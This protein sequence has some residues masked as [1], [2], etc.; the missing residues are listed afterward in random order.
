MKAYG[1]AMLVLAAASG[2]R[3][4][5]PLIP[6]PQEITPGRGGFSIT[7]SAVIYV[8]RPG[9]PEDRLAAFSLRDE[10][11]LRTG[12]RLGVRQ[13]IPREAAGI[14]LGV[15]G[16][17]EEIREQVARPVTREQGYALEVTPGSIAICG[18][19]SAGLFYGMQTLLQLLPERGSAGL[20][21]S[22]RAIPAL[23]IR[24]WPALRYRMVQYDIARGQ[25]VNVAF[26][27][28]VIRTLAHYKINQ[29]MFY[30]EDDFK[31]RAYPFLGREGT[32]THENASELSRFARDYHVELVPEIES[33]GHAGALLS[34]PELADLRDA[35]N[36]WNFCPC[37]PGTLPF[38]GNVYTEL[39]D[40]FG[41]GF[42]HVGG[43]EFEGGF[44]KD[45]RCKG[46]LAEWGFEG[47]YARYMTQLDEAVKARGRRMMIWAAH[48]N[49]LTL[50][51]GD[52]LSKNMII[53]EWIYHGP[54]EYP[55]IERYQ[56]AGFEVYVVPSVV[57]Y[58]RIYPDYETTFRAV[59]G[60]IG[61]GAARGVMGECTTTWE[62]MQGA[63]FENSWYGL[64]YSADCGWAPQQA[65]KASFDERFAALWFG[66]P[67]AGREM[68]AL[69]TDLVGGDGFWRD[70]LLVTQIF[71]ASPERVRREF[72]GPATAVG[73]D[74]RPPLPEQA[75]RLVAAADA[76]V[77]RIEALR[78]RVRR[79]HL[80]LDTVE[81]AARMYG[82][83]G[84]KM[85]LLERAA[86]AY[87][88]AAAAA[89][90][91]EMAR[92]LAEA[93]AALR[94]LLG[95]YGYFEEM[96]RD[97]ADHRGHY[98]GDVDRVA[99]QRQ[100]LQALIARLDDLR[101]AAAAGQKPALPPASE[102]ALEVAH[103]VKAAAWS[104][105]Q[106]SPEWTTVRYDIT[107]LVRAAGEYLVTW[108]Y[109][110]GALGLAIQ[111]TAIESDGKRVAED[112]HEGW[113]GAAMSNNTYRLR[114]ESVAP[115]ARYELV[116][117]VRSPTGTDSS[118]E[119]WINAPG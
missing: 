50:R 49:D 14:A 72:V 36:P 39:A 116:G 96:L 91:A 24:D 90:P 88:A 64:I 106:M 13:G 43:D 65:E 109:T 115:G 78:P 93:T 80:T 114:I 110:S 21:T 12:L 95:P 25:T 74:G 46:P 99:Q 59:R 29:L 52:R 9:S 108:R 69:L 22:G 62:L 119:I 47:L 60:F 40:A 23:T 19:D 71:W 38:L 83:A 66:A 85:V 7:P 104:P 28:H 76:A 103:W 87:R 89:E 53:F 81:L 73:A 5:P 63:L 33:L 55:T 18:A 117:R 51:A 94:E 1:W 97:A 37:A 17:D 77:A 35:G 118:G 26:C 68:G 107:P 58:S 4:A 6:Q 27:K 42:L 54:A 8:C 11:R 45:E 111:N 101:E 61:A 100:E 34:H 41:G 30:L 105:A 32:F 75:V 20:T 48:E 92:R 112:A 56:Q 79:N 3:A 102:F 44:A 2:A 82:H 67:G 57:D 86:Q 15:L 113:S 31:Y 84:R 98:R 10:I 16:R 70:G